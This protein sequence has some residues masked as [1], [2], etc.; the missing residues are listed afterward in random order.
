MR[1]ARVY[2][3]THRHSVARRTDKIG[4]AVASLPDRRAARSI[5]PRSLAPDHRS[6]AWSPSHS[7]GHDALTITARRRHRAGELPTDVSERAE[8][9]VVAARDHG[10]GRRH[11]VRI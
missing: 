8:G 6:S 7:H 9:N 1:L 10:A 2:R 4:R 5:A 11:E 3:D